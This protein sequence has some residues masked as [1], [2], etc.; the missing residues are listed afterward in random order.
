[1]GGG[2]TSETMEHQQYL[3]DTTA[4]MPMFGHIELHDAEVLPENIT[5]EHLRAF[6]DLY[7]THCEVRNDRPYNSQHLI[8]ISRI[9]FSE[10]N[11]LLCRVF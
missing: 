8:S 4:A 7:N 9:Y 11:F 1:M 6:E 2:A 5:S 3:G 10:A